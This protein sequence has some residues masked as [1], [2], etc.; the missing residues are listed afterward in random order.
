MHRSRTYTASTKWQPPD[1]GGFF[2]T[3]SIGRSGL[4]D[5]HIQP[6]E[7][8]EHLHGAVDDLSTPGSPAEE[9]GSGRRVREVIEKSSNGR[10]QRAGL[11]RSDQSRRRG[12]GHHGEHGSLCSRGPGPVPVEPGEDSPG[13]KGR[14]REA[15]AETADILGDAPIL[16]IQNGNPQFAPS[17][18]WCPQG[19]LR[20]AVT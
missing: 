2:R 15:Q 3:V 6:V 4:E 7:S 14:F 11:L 10:T 8:H 20:D 19:S 18:W 16:N 13:F 1:L 9:I 12:L 17:F 5:G